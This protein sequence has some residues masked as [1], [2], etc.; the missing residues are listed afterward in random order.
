MSETTLPVRGELPRIAARIFDTPLLIEQRKL[1]QILAVL[2]PRLGAA[3]TDAFK[4]PD[5]LVTKPG[6]TMMSH[7]AQIAGGRWEWDKDGRYYHVGD[8]AVIPI[9]GT[10]V[11]RS[12][13]VDAYSGLI[14]YER[15]EASVD[16]AMNDRTVSEI[17]FDYDSPGGEAAGAF[18]TADRLFG[19]RG[20]KPMTAIVNESATSGAYL[21]AATADAVVTTR[22]GYTGSVGV[23]SAHV[24]MSVALEK[25]GLAVTLLYAGEKKVDGHPYGPLP[26]RVRTE[27]LAEIGEMYGIFVSAVARYR[28]ISEESVR[29]TQAGVFMGRAGLGIG[30]ADR[31]NSLANEVHNSAV[32]RGGNSFSLAEQ[33]QEELAVNETD[34]TA[35]AQAVADAHARG[36][37]EGKAAATAAAQTAAAAE[38]ERVQKITTSEAA[39]GRAELAAHLAYET[40]VS[41]EAA[42]K[43]LAAAPQAGAGSLA[44][45]MAQHGS[46]GIR[47]VDTDV[48]AAAAAKSTYV[49]DEAKNFALLNAPYEKQL[50]GV[51]VKPN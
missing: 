6:D 10:L 13:W 26:D 44:E 31:V 24:D 23:V 50:V 47:T 35:Q 33:P 42:E 19:R 36:I 48:D 20:E 43:I 8:V 9:V 22:T 25:R 16:H 7:R 51:T 4:D 2:G 11:Q 34:K 38:R 32:K 40:D 27:W 14:S 29:K 37:A 41:P 46:P 5:A 45:A 3:G 15:I 17:F 12:S 1:D 18:D 28:G 39:K 21:L 49:F 30:F